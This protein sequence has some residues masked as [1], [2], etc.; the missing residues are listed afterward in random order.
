MCGMAVSLRLERLA[1]A[2]LALRL[3]IEHNLCTRMWQL[4]VVVYVHLHSL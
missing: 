4:R 1:Q 3:S 2:A